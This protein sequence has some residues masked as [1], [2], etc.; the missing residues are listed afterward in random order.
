MPHCTF[1]KVVMGNQF[2]ILSG[3]IVAVNIC[4]YK[5]NTFLIKP[6][7]DFGKHFLRMIPDL[8]LINVTTD[9]ML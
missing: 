4:D 2:L 7:N 6:R 5:N 3:L 8:P 9:N 1:T